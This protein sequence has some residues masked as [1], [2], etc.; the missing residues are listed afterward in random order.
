MKKRTIA[1]LMAV[2]LLFGVAVGGTIAWLQDETEV[3]TNTFVTGNIDIEL[4]ETWN[5]DKTGDGTNDAWEV[6]LIPGTDY[7]KDPYVT[8][9]ANSEKCW[10]FVKVEDSNNELINGTKTVQYTIDTANWTLVTGE[11]NVYYYNTPFEY[12]DTDYAPVYVFAGKGDGEYK[13]GYVT[14]NSGLTKEMMNPAEGEDEYDTP[15]IS[16]TAYAVQ[17]D[18]FASASAAW[19]ATYGA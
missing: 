14:I 12:S 6:K 15:A 13:N 19:D 2:V 1:L 11:T 5:T 18:N 9:K 17:Y 4:D 16:I 10:V 7:K 8:V 3:V